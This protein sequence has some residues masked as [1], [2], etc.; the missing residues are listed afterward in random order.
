MEDKD[1]KPWAYFVAFDELRYYGPG[2]NASV[3][4]DI[5]D[6][7]IIIDE[8][9][10]IIDL[11]IHNASKYLSIEEIKRLAEIYDPR[12]LE[13]EIEELKKKK[14]SFKNREL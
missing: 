4:V 5:G 3:H 9:G 2:V 1:L 8:N 7:E 11:V 12:E 13:K 10:E 14:F 6:V